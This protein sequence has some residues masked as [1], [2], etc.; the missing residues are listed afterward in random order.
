MW[1]FFLSLIYLIARLLFQKV[2]KYMIDTINRLSVDINVFMDEMR[3]SDDRIAYVKSHSH[4]ISNSEYPGLCAYFNNLRYKFKGYENFWS[5]F[6]YSEFIDISGSAGYKSR[7]IIFRC[8]DVNVYTFIRLQDNIGLRKVHRT[9]YFAI[10]GLCAENG[11]E[12]IERHVA[13]ILS[14]EYEFHVELKIKT[15]YDNEPAFNNNYYMISDDFK[16]MQR[17]KWRSS[18]GINKLSDLITVQVK[19]YH[20]LTDDDK[21]NIAELSKTWYSK[22]TILKNLTAVRDIKMM[23]YSHQDT[24]LYILYYIGDSLVAHNILFMYDKFSYVCVLKTISVFG[25]EYLEDHFDS[26]TSKL[27]HSYLLNFV[28]YKC[29]QIS[30]CDFSH[31]TMY[32]GG[33]TIRNDIKVYDADAGREKFIKNPSV[34]NLDG[35]KSRLFKRKIEYIK[36]ILC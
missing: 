15:E 34:H 26:E 16:D 10:Y 22:R 7:F 12:N 5:D 23:E 24:Y 32:I 21:R 8:C 19:R 1:V 2:L 36:R 31:E 4:K 18:H 27:L 33:H 3:C 35:Y 6:G 25:M 28:I 14:S 9:P 11:D 13:E 29:A 20:E 17:S 30:F